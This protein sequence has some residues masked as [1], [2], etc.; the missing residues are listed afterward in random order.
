[1]S[2]I[3][4]GSYAFAFLF[5]SFL[6]F[7]TDP[8]LLVGAIA[9]GA[10][11]RPAWLLVMLAL[12]FSI[13]LSLYVALYGVAPSGRL[14]PLLVFIRWAAILAVAF[15]ANIVRRLSSVAA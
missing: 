10:L 11:A 9:I 14:V 5:S 6:A 1:V 3:F 8:L 12:V 15:L 7:L 13:A 4:A 2:G